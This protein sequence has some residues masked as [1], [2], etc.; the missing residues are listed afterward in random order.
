[1]RLGKPFVNLSILNAKIICV[2]HDP[3]QKRGLFYMNDLLP[4]L[5]F[6]ATGVSFYGASQDYIFM[7]ARRENVY[8]FIPA[9]PAAVSARGFLGIEKGRP[10]ERPDADVGKKLLVVDVAGVSG[11][12]IHPCPVRTC[13][14]D[15]TPPGLVKCKRRFEIQFRPERGAGAIP[16]SVTGIV[17]CTDVTPGARTRN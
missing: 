17:D 5:R 11:D 13:V 12:G 7:R 1:M 8:P 4:G 9:L 14:I 16:R 6:A 2:I 15:P 10:C 3:A